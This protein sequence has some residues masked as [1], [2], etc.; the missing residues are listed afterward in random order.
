MKSTGL[1][2]G[3]YFPMHIGHEYYLTKASSL[4]DELIICVCANDTQKFLN[5]TPKDRHLAMVRFVADN[6]TNARVVFFDDKAMP[7]GGTNITKSESLEV[8]RI[9]ADEFK[10]L[11]PAVT[12][13]ITSEDYGTEVADFMQVQHICVDQQ[14]QKYPVSATLI[15]NDVVNNWHLMNEYMKKCSAIKICIY[16]SES[17]GKSTTAK[18]LAEKFKGEF[19]PEAARYL[20]TDMDLTPEIFEDIAIGQYASTFEKAPKNFLQFVDTDLMI[21]QNYAQWY[22][23][24]VPAMVDILQKR[25]KYDLY[26]LLAPTVPWVD[27]NLRNISEFEDRW[28]MHNE[29]KDKLELNGT[30]FIEIT[31]TDYDDRFSIAASVVTDLISTR[32]YL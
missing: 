14:R 4:V 9:W 32:A 17:C 13:I 11:F 31:A 5:I 19:I 8:S 10:E 27:D 24:E 21:T 26:I 25:E 1:A 18:M 16:G 7:Q 30:K 23:G 28:C 20:L 12:H 22:L 2:F 29:L 6:L 15:R 3:K